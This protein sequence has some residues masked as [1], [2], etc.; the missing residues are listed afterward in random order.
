MDYMADDAAALATAPRFAAAAVEDAALRSKLAL[1][2][3]R[4]GDREQ[5]E[6]WLR[7]VADDQAAVAWLALTRRAITDRRADD[8][9]AFVKSARGAGAPAAD[10]VLCEA[11]IAALQRQQW[12]SPDADIE[13]LIAAGETAEAEALAAELLA[14][15][16]EAAIARRVIAQARERRRSAEREWLLEEARQ[17][18]SRGD[19]TTASSRSASARASGADT[20]AVEAAIAAA[21]EAARGQRERERVEN[22]V[23]RLVDR[24]SREALL[25]YLDLPPEL[26]VAVK[27]IARRDVL[28]WLDHFSNLSGARAAATVTAVMALE[29]LTTDDPET[30]LAV[31]TPHE[32]VLQRVPFARGQIAKTK[33][34]IAARQRATAEGQITAVIAALDADDLDRAKVLLAKV[35]KDALDNT[36][37]ERLL[38]TQARLDDARELARRIAAVNE[39]IS[40]RDFLGAQNAIESLCEIADE[41]E[42]ERWKVR[43]DEL[44]ESAR[45]QWPIYDLGVTGMPIAELAL[46]GGEVAADCQSLPVWYVLDADRLV[47]AHSYSRWLIL[48]VIEVSTQRLS[49]GLVVPLPSTLGRREVTAWRGRIWIVGDDHLLEVDLNAGTVRAWRDLRELLNTNTGLAVSHVLPDVNLFWAAGAGHAVVANLSRWERHRDAKV[50]HSVAR[51][52]GGR[53]PIIA[54]FNDLGSIDVH[55]ADGEARDRLERID[56]QIHALALHP[57]DKKRRVAVVSRMLTDRNGPL[58]ISLVELGK[59]DHYPLA[60]SLGSRPHGLL[61]PSNAK[62]A[63]VVCAHG[64]HGGT[65]VHGFRAEPDLAPIWTTDISHRLV[66][67][68]DIESRR[69]LALYPTDRGMSIT[70]LGQHQPVFDGGITVVGYLPQMA[71]PFRCSLSA[72]DADFM[73]AVA[74]DLRGLEGAGLRTMIE[75]LQRANATNSYNLFAMTAVLPIA[76]RSRHIDF[77]AERYPGYAPVEIL[78]ADFDALLGAWDRVIERL[79]ALVVPSNVAPCRPHRLHLLGIARLRLGD[80]ERALQT[81]REARTLGYGKLCQTIECIEWIEA[82]AER[83]HEEGPKSTKAQRVVRPLGLGLYVDVDTQA[84]QM[85][86]ALRAADGCFATEDYDGVVRALERSTVLAHNEGQSLA[87]L[88]TAL[89]A[90]PA[91]DHAVR[92]RT[93]GVLMRFCAWMEAGSSRTEVFLPGATWD[94]ERLAAIYRVAEFWLGEK[95]PAGRVNGGARLVVGP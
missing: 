60:E 82:L 42:R 63:L 58:P 72:G 52:L 88:A 71:A 22:V 10:V 47:V 92:L 36:G 25:D 61:T 19:T 6:S 35:D 9:A 33:A 3:A 40:S 11:E 87:R 38:A 17:A 80:R 23:K 93:A 94:A 53:E 26:R 90:S 5:V 68:Q 91:T 77:V 45:R 41:Q 79:D 15:W 85:V 34:A 43:A 56:H 54:S 16:P 55:M 8:A 7:G 44:A 67:A 64:D 31:L 74:D 27:R 66:L 2:A 86:R 65:R 78:R 20:S 70:E 83:P 14:H 62:A 49:R 21:V 75:T 48:F 37:R 28:T 69:A 13:R 1:A 30:V 29:A 39:R 73:A 95:F 76:E 81:F 57:A 89:V 4:M 84:Q 18:L 32:E 50:G 46:L 24:T 12:S 59:R 51:L